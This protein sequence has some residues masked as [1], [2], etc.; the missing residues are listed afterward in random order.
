MLYRLRKRAAP[1]KVAQ[2][3]TRLMSEIA[4]GEESAERDGWIDESD[5]LEEFG[6]AK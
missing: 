1:P 2:A 4:T 3:V 6:S 5:I